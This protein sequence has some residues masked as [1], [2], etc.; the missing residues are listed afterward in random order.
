MITITKK[1]EI[2]LNQIKIFNW[3]YEEGIPES[4]I[5]ME[6]GIYEHELREILNE[7]ASKNLISYENKKI[8]LDSSKK[9]INAVD[10]RKDVIKADLNEKEESTLKIIQDLVD[11]DSVVSKYSLEGS[12]LYGELHLSDF[13]MYHILLSLE[14]KGILKPIN[15]KDGEYYLLVEN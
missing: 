10:S 8:K 6:L 5:K 4:L 11:K 1:E 3:E 15:R 9:D 7:L 13:R 12:L 14:N 2:V